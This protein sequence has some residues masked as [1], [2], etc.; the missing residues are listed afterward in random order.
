VAFQCISFF[1]A[2][3]DQLRGTLVLWVVVRSR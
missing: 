1:Q 3:F 2:A